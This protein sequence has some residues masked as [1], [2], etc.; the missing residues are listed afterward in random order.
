MHDTYFT[1]GQV[2]RLL[3]KKP[4]L[5]TYAITSG[6]IAEPALRLGNKRVFGEVDM[7]RLARHFGVPMPRVE[8]AGPDGESQSHHLTCGDGPTLAGPFSV[9]RVGTTGHEVRDAHGEV[10][11]WAADRPRALVLA[12]LLEHACG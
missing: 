12:G 3:G 9:D 11:C 2:A 6:H 4:H 8:S 7:Q 10:F 1:L 5:I